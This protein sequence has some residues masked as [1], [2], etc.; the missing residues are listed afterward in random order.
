MPDIVDA[1]TRS[2]MMSRIR[3]K[4][5]QPEM[6][7]RRRLHAAGIRYRLHVNSL[8]GKPDLVLRG[9]RTAVF[10]HGCFWHQHRDCRLATKPGTNV[11][12]WR[13]KLNANVDRDALV[14]AKLRQNGWQVETIWECDPLQ[15]ID[16]L[17][18]RI[19]RRCAPTVGESSPR[20]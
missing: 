3:G 2:R 11:D 18:H 10:V 17:A 15:S 7:V 8:P 12:F 6:R 4:D 16:A 5:T 20:G 13:N 9:A 1:A 14:E 19:R